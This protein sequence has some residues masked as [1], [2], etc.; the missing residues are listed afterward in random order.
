M[1]RYRAEFYDRWGTLHGCEVE[2]DDWFQAYM[3]AG[4]LFVKRYGVWAGSRDRR[5]L[6]MSE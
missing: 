4:D 1:N 3:L 6:E 2:A 5:V